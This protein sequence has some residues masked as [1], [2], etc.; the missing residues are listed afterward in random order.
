MSALFVSDM[1]PPYLEMA[2]LGLGTIALVAA[3]VV[4]GLFLLRRFRRRD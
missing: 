2:G 1:A 3:L 4:G